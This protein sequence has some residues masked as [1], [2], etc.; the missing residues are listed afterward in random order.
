MAHQIWKNSGGT[1]WKPTENSWRPWMRGPPKKP[2]PSEP[3]ITLQYETSLSKVWVQTTFDICCHTWCCYRGLWLPVSLTLCQW[4]RL[5]KKAYFCVLYHIEKNLSIISVP[6][7]IFNQAIMCGSYSK[8][9]KYGSPGY[10][11]QYTCYNVTICGHIWISAEG[12][13]LTWNHICGT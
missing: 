5:A 1:Y 10:L 11:W 6:K 4:G 13:F 2:F 7:I 3:L 8:T 12:A 9:E